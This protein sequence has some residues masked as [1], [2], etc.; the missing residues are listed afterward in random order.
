MTS[1]ILKMC[2]LLKIN[3]KPCFDNLL[4]TCRRVFD[5]CSTTFRRLFDEFSTDL[6][7]NAGTEKTK[8]V[9]MTFHLILGI[10]HT[11]GR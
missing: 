2:F 4:T 5:D 9:T 11:A 8:K 3:Q 10:Q 6:R 7:R 1:K